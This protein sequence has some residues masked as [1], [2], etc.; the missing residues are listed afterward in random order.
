MIKPSLP[1]CSPQLLIVDDVPENLRLLKTVLQR[2]GYQVRV[3]A[4]GKFALTSLDHFKPDLILLDIMMPEMNGY[5]FCQ[6]LKENPHTA[7]IP[8]IF[9]SALQDGIDKAK[10]FQIGGA[11]YLTKPFQIEELLA[12]VRHHLQLREL[13]DQ[14]Q[15]KNRALEAQNQQLQ[16]TQRTMAL[17]L[18][19]TQ[20]INQ[21]FD[22]NQAIS[23]VL[24]QVCRHISWHYAE[25]WIPNS[26]ETFLTYICCHK[27]QLCEGDKFQKFR[28]ISSQMTFALNE[29]L[30][31][32]IWFSQEPEWIDDCSCCQKDLYLRQE[33][34]GQTGFKSVFGVPIV[35]NKKVL[36][37]LVFY[38]EEIKY[39]EPQL[40]NLIQSIVTQLSSALD[41]SKL[42]QKLEKANEELKQLA[43]RDGLTQVAN[44]RRFDEILQKEW[45]RLK[46]EQGWLSLILC[47]VDYFKKYNDFYGHL[48]GDDCLIK[49]AQTLHEAVRRPA[50]LVARYGGEEFGIILPNTDGTGACKVASIVQELIWNLR[51]PHELSEIT[52]YVTLSLGISSGIP[53]DRRS[54]KELINT[55]DCALYQAKQ[56]G[57]NQYCFRDLEQEL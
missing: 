37:I 21:A 7:D 42:Y 25:A 44:R 20:I 38:H 41:K 39:C 22:I 48:L 56:S 36:S 29:G 34:A 27:C 45:F 8:I 46:R 5:A 57:R 53:S 55:A 28:Q 26:D 18:N 33:L 35:S 19:V 23:E 13:Q 2:E 40:I 47:D 51:I 31:G 12:R 11:D 14:L 3:A 49:I 17:M 16:Q 9:L 32:R 43:N 54:P 52:N 10:A 4:N 24:Y 50:D 15:Q 6:S 1:E 30:P